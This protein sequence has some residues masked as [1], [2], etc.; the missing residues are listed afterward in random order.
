MID[1]NTQL[2]LFFSSNLSTS[3]NGL[4]NITKSE[5]LNLIILPDYAVESEREGRGIGN[6]FCSLNFSSFTK[7]LRRKIF[8]MPPTPLT[9][10]KGRMT[11]KNWIHWAS[12]VWETVKKASSYVDY[13]RM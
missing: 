7:D 9:T 10:N 4:S 12:K 13:S 3:A 11:E 5:D 1:F 2:T 6:R 8:S